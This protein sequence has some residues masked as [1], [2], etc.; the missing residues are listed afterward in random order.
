MAIAAAG[1]GVLSVI[2]HTGEGLPLEVRWLLVGSVAVALISISFLMR[3]IQISKKHHQI[4][5]RG[6]MAMLISGIVILFL[7]FSSLGTIPL[8][9]TVVLLMLIPVF[10]GLKA[11]IQVPRTREI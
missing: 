11:L 7:G 6:G 5:Q 4:Y 1:A 3:T 2:A 8:L 10:Y 9:I